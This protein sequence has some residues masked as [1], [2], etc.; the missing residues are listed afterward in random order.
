MFTSTERDSAMHGVER[1]LS[2]R[3][4]VLGFKKY[5]LL[6]ADIRAISI[7]KYT[8]S[9]SLFYLYIPKLYKYISIIFAI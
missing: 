3:I 4:V 1:H 7:T 8:Y 2:S 5:R 6:L 9:W